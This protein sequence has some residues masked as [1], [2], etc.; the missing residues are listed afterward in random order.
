MF[1]AE[2]G[3]GYSQY[4][5]DSSGADT[6]ANQSTILTRRSRFEKL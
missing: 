4:E 3:Y 2:A 1:T 6:V 5:L